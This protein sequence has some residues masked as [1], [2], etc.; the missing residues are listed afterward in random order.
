MLIQFWK[1]GYFYISK[2][3]SDFNYNI[4]S[5]VNIWYYFERS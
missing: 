3:A 1:Q 2:Q 4:K 5:G